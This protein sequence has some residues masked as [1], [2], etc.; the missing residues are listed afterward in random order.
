L[1]A[2]ATLVQSA[3]RGDPEAGLLSVS[4]SQRHLASELAELGFP[5]GQ[6]LAGRLLPPGLR[7]TSEQQDP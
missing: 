5:V 7:P 3:I 4:K 1:E 6:K 2:L